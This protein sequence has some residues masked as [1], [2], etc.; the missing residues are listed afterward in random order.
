[1]LFAAIVCRGS[2]PEVLSGLQQREP[3]CCTD[4]ARRCL[5]LTNALT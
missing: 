2:R 3:S 1:M 5:N 4:E